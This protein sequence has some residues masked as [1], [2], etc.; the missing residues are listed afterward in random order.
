MVDLLLKVGK[1]IVLK[2]DNSSFVF[3]LD[4]NK[5]YDVIPNEPAVGCYPKFGPVFL[6]F[7]IR[8]YD[9]FFIKGGSTWH[10]GLNYRTRKD[11][12]LNNGKQTYLIKDIEVYR[13]ESIDIN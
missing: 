11:F 13:I 1:A 2:K 10:R 4:N 3:N 7:Q 6:G 12:E 5:I 9:E 8:I